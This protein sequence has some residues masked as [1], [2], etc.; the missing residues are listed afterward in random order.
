MATVLSMKTLEELCLTHVTMTLEQYSTDTLSLLP[1]GFRV[2]SYS[3]RYRL[4]T[5]VDWKILNSSQGS[6]WSL[7][8]GNLL[9]IWNLY[10]DNIHTIGIDDVNQA[11]VGD[12]IPS[13]IEGFWKHKFFGAFLDFLVLGSRPYGNFNY[14][15]VKEGDRTKRWYCQCSTHFIMC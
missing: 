9:L 11:T 5:F 4:L 12:V 10:G 14:A 13:S 7:F 3:T 6:I 1:K 8:G 15:F 2:Y